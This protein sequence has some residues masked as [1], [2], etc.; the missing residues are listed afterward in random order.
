MM[1][2]CLNKLPNHSFV[3]VIKAKIILSDNGSQFSSTVRLRKQIESDIT[4]RLS[5]IRHPEQQ[6]V[7]VIL[8]LSEFFSIYCHDNHTKLAELLPHIE[9]WLNK[10]VKTGYSATELMFREKKN[11][12]FDKMLP[13]LKYDVL[14]IE[15]LD[16]ILERAFS[17]IKRKATGRKNKEERK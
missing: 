2:A 17:K 16:T 12:I 10:A 15:D 4:T 7:R 14:D 11:G 5:P 1:K 6:S 3:N 9:E 8:E 13:E